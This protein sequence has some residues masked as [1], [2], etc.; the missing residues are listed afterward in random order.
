MS[1]R[2]YQNTSLCTLLSN[3]P[4][5]NENSYNGMLSRLPLF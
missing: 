3:H 5:T 2:K 4:D 1:L